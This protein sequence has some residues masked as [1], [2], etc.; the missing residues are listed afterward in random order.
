MIPSPLSAPLRPAFR[1]TYK[2]SSMTK[3]ELFPYSK[4]LNLKIE[5]LRCRNQ[6]NLLAKD[7]S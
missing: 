2:V 5:L 4:H 6:P 1:I 7:A 3:L